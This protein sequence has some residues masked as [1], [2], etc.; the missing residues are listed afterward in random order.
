MRSKWFAT[1]NAFHLINDPVLVSINDNGDH[2][3]VTFQNVWTNESAV[4]VTDLP[5]LTIQAVIDGGMVAK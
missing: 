5:V 2:R 1:A 3:V 4:E